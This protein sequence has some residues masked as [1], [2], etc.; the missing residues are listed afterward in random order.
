MPVFESGEAAALSVSARRRRLQSK[1]RSIA[2]WDS[3]YRRLMQ[4]HD[5]G[6]DLDARTPEVAALK[7]ELS[8]MMIGTHPEF[9]RMVD[10]YMTL[11]D[12][13]AIRERLIGSGRIGGKAADGP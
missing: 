6:L 3:V 12:L 8:R 10:T 2:P 5:A 11:D 9:S 13:L 1:A 7:Q 4:Y